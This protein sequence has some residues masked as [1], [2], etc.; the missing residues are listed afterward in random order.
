MNPSVTVFNGSD[1]PLAAYP[2]TDESHLHEQVL[3]QLRDDGEPTLAKLF[4]EHR[5]R[6]QRPLSSRHRL[7]QHRKNGRRQTG[8]T[9]LTNPH[10]H[11]LLTDK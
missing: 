8:E 1:F 11:F 5:E 7:T 4:D 3:E 2:M 9:F 6:L 10:H